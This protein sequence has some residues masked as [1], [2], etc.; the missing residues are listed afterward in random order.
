MNELSLRIIIRELCVDIAFGQTG[1][2]RVSF[3]L[4]D[5]IGERARVGNRKEPRYTIGSWVSIKT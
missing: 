5:G 4:G 1:R 2:P 3:Y